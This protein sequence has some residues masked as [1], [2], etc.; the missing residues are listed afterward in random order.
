VPRPLG[1]STLA[2][3]TF[4]SGNVTGVKLHRLFDLTGQVAI[5]TGSTKGIGKAI[6][7]AFAQAGAKVVVSSRKEDKCREVADAIQAAGGEAIAVPCNISHKEQLQA[8]V[9][10]ALHSWGRIDVLVCNAAVNPYYGPL[11]EIPEAAYD[12][13]MDTNVKSNLWL[14]NMVAP[15]MAARKDGAIVIVS[16]I[17]GLKGSQNLGA[18]GLSKAADMQLARNL[19][20][21]WG[22]DNIRVNCIAPG[23][24]RTDFARA[25]WEDPEANA[26]AVASYPLGRLGEP[27]DIA[28]AALFLAARSG[29]FVTG[30]TLVVDGGNTIGSGRYS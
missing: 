19:A 10:A 27:E 30:Q 13:I 5:V 17:G 24:V 15:L 22:P 1:V 21:E 20:V 11:A 18:Y 28:G 8:L 29:R 7:E 14:C 16:S 26:R 4:A 23:L 3:R 25:L 6:V 2:E 12:K 9:D